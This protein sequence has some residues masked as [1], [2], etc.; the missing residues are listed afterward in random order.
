MG[1]QAVGEGISGQELEE[2]QEA[3]DLA[4]SRREIAEARVRGNAS[5]GSLERLAAA[6]LAA[7]QARFEQT[8]IVAPAAGT[9]LQRLVQPGDVVAAGAG[10]LDLAPEGPTWL[11]VQPEEK[12][13]AFLRVGQSAQ[14]SADAYPDSVFSARIARLAPA[15]DPERGT[16]EVELVDGR[17][18]S[19][20][21][22]VR[23]RA[24]R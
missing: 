15:V 11:A 18:T 3:S 23:G 5:G 12:N 1:C 9:I 21:E 10:L 20:R 7:A 2:A 14:A 24:G 16:I 17:I 22:A 4:Q 13:L 19:E 8:R 6:E